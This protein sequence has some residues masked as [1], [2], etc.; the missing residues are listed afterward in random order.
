[1]I[2]QT[3]KPKVQVG[4]R[5]PESMLTELRNI[6]HYEDRTLNSVL[7]RMIRSALF[8]RDRDMRPVTLREVS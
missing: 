6:A 7:I 2:G 8:Q 4:L 1:M 3:D 5:L